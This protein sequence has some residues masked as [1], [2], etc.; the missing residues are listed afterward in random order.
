[1]Q[2]SSSCDNT[3]TF[4]TATSERTIPPHNGGSHNSISIS[5]SNDNTI[6]PLSHVA[7]ISG[8][9]DFFL[10]THQEVSVSE[11]VTVPSPSI[12][13]TASASAIKAEATNVSVTVT[14]NTIANENECNLLSQSRG[15]RVLFATDEWFASAEHL[16]RDEEPTFDPDAY[17]PEGK[18][19]DGW[20]TRRRREAGHDWCILRLG[21]RGTV[22]RIVIDTAYFTGNHV[23]RI[24]LQVTDLLDAAQEAQWVTQLPG[25]VERLLYGSCAPQQGT[26]ATPEQVA[27]AEHACAR[28]P[29]VWRELLPATPLQPGYDNTRHHEFVLPTTTTTKSSCTHVRVNYYPDGG[30]ARLRLYGTPLP[31]VAPQPRPL[32]SPIVT[33][34]TCAVLR[35]SHSDH[36]DSE[37][38]LF[39]ARPPFPELT[40]GG[41]GVACSNQ[42]YGEPTNLL[43][44]TLG[45]DMGDGWETARHAHRPAIWNKDPVSQLMESDLSDWCVLQLGQPAARVLAVL[46]D[47]KH[48]RGNYPESVLVEGCCYYCDDHDHHDDDIF[49]VHNDNSNDDDDDIANNINNTDADATEPHRVVWFPLVP[50]GRMAPD[51]EHLY[52]ANQSY[53]DNHG[54][55]QTQVLNS[56]RPVTHVRVQIYPD[57]GLSRVRVYGVPLQ[58]S[59]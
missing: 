13:A 11:E 30:V 41:V 54:Q 12:T 19:M 2:R 38:A 9:Q 16:L 43:Q 33:G 31:A 28:V 5:N 8:V 57:G 23:P 32:Y 42:H 24:S 20:E 3:L 36:P 47:T 34:R 39:S 6:H 35:H 44:A 14:P 53:T 29:S 18:V 26:G 40:L 22:H 58:Q 45:R 49:A 7:S 37:N 48:F 59:P 27:L 56:D 55:P 10:A 1:M 21:Q 46:L 52:Q 51:A 4:T 15:A 50:R 17:C 25:A